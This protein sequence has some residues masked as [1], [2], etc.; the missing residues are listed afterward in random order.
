MMEIL[1]VFSVMIAI[2][3]LAA[4]QEV[5][6]PVD[7]NDITG[8][9][10]L[11]KVADTAL[12]GTVYHDDVALEIRSGTFIISAD[13]KPF[14]TIFHKINTPDALHNRGD[15]LLR[16][17][18]ILL[19]ILHEKRLVLFVFFQDLEVIR[20]EKLD[21]LRIFGSKAPVDQQD[22]DNEF[23]SDLGPQKF[24]DVAVLQTF[25]HI[26]LPGNRHIGLPVQKGLDGRL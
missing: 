15:L 2:L 19:Q 10:Y 7:D 3:T 12:P 8:I 11:L 17:T 26:R 1:R 25:G 23:F 21:H 9:Y 5:V 22:I 14:L 24:D 4:C 18:G 16:K 20:H 6:R 13:A